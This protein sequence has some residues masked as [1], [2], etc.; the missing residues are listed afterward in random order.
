MNAS[1]PDASEPY[2]AAPQRLG[3]LIDQCIKGSPNAVILVAQII[4][5]GNPATNARVQTFDAAI[6]EVVAQRTDAGHHVMVVDMRQLTSDEMADVLH[7]NAAGYKTMAN[8][9][10]AGLQ[11]VDAKGWIQRPVG[12]DPITVNKATCSK[13][14]KSQG[15]QSQGQQ[16]QGQQS[17]GQ[18]RKCRSNPV[19]YNPRGNDV[20]ATGVGHGGNGKFAVDWVPVPSGATGIGRN[21]RGVQFVSRVHLS[22]ALQS[23]FTRRISMETVVPTTCGWTKPAEHS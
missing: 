15:Q 8:V 3:S 6:P 11:A 4:N 2:D 19:W 23:D 9:W 16:S 12:I 1:P 14:Q 10:L 18:K 7:P 17:Q 22:S 20:I 13:V 21:G 5:S